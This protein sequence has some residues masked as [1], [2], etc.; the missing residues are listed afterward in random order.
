MDSLKTEKWQ[1]QQ[2]NH[3]LV[4]PAH[5]QMLTNILADTNNIEN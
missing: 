3:H 2:V 4:T 5:I 1:R